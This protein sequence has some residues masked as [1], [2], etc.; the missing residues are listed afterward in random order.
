MELRKFIVTTIREYLNEQQ[1]LNENLEVNDYSGRYEDLYNFINDNNLQT[2][3]VNKYNIFD[4][5]LT[6]QNW[7]DFV[8]GEMGTDEEIIED[9][10]GKGYRIYYDDNEDMFIVSKKKIGKLKY[11]IILS[12][13]NKI[14]NVLEECGI[15]SEYEPRFAINLNSKIIGGSTYNIDDD[16]VYNFDI[17]I[18]DEYQGYGI[19][20]QLIDK[21][22]L[23]AK[24]LK[25]DGMKAQIVNNMLFDYLIKRGFKGSVDSGIKYVYTQF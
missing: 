9:L 14:I 21:I 17:G 16:N 11:N 12:N 25:C 20:K 18:L 8:R 22:I 3:F 24:H 7:E 10:L 1:M 19:S 2:F 15:H 4:S 13:N 5:D 6:I 23:D